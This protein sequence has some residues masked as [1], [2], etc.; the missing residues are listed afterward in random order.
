M[1][2][3]ITDLLSYSHTNITDRK[4]E[5]ADLNTIL[6]E[7][8]SDLAES[9][10]E[11][12]AVVQTVSVCKVNII[13]FQFRQ[14]ILNLVANALKFSKPGIPAQIKITSIAATGLQLLQQNAQLAPESLFP[15]RNYCCITISD[16][17][18][19]FDP[20][21]GDKIFEVFQRLHGKEDYEG[22]G[23]GL[24]VVRRAA[25]R[26]G[27]AILVESEVGKGSTFHLELNGASWE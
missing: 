2:A 18:I 14:L 13:P 23:I 19:G 4:F 27:G 8:K 6:D 7:V 20:Q 21:F 9:I 12:N 10:L 11:K 16:N 3:L 1:Q 5:E 22:T 15:G 17:G 24:A 25:E 26:M